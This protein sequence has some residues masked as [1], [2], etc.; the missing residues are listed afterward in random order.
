[1]SISFV[2]GNGTSRTVV[3]CP[4]L[5]EHGIVYGCNAVYR[6][7]I[8]DK[9]ISVDYRMI[10]EVIRN[11]IPQQCEFW[12]NY[13]AAFEQYS[14]LNM[15]NPSKGWGSGPTALWLAANEKPQEI[16]I[17]GFDYSGLGKFVN[18]V[19]AGTTNYK[20]KTDTATFYGNWLTQTETVIR[21]NP[22]VKFIR[23][24]GESCLDVHWVQYRNFKQMPMAEF[25]EKFNV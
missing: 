9:L 18:N 10:K 15:I 21:D 6:D 22:F 25:K 3:D 11:K 5:K 14:D 20:K 19:Y 7:F 23:V 13:N 2:L 17:L 1:M 8:P 16:Y 12:T 24:V 4:K